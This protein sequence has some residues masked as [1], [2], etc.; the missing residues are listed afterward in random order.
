MR[1]AYLQL[2]S[3]KSNYNQ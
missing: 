1:I 3:L 2:F